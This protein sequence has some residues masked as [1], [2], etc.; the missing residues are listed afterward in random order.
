MKNKLLSFVLLIGIQTAYSQ[1][2]SLDYSSLE[3]KMLKSDAAIKEDKQKA[4]AKTWL[5]R[6]ELFQDINDVNIQ[7]IR[8]GMSTTEAKIFYKAPLEIKN[9]QTEKGAG[10][11][12]DY[13]RIHLVFVNGKLIDWTEIKNLVENPLAESYN[14]FKKCISI[15]TVGKYKKDL[16]TDLERFKKQAESKGVYEYNKKDFDKALEFFEYSYDINKLPYFNGVVDTAIIYNLGIV[17]LKANKNDKAVKYFKEAIVYH[18]GES[19]SY[20]HLR[21]AYLAIGDT[22]SA[23]NILKEGADKYPESTAMLIELINY[24]LTKGEAKTALE[25]LKLAKQKDTTNASFYFAEG[26]LHEKLNEPELALAA[27]T[28]AIQLDPKNFNS[29][30]NL[31]AFYYNKAVKMMAT[32]NDIMD[33]KKYEIAKKDAEFV[34]KQAIPYLE[35]AHEIKSDD[36]STSE[37]LKNLYFRLMAN[38]A[39]LKEKFEKI[40]A[41]IEANKK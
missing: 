28:K 30:Y 6:G 40:K 39:T 25:Y 4:K 33:N 23:L 27:Y 2:T 38:D 22:V 13:E 32:A 9:V 29:F 26:T 5:E 41:E 10:E 1:Q 35:K 14:S 24:Y 7:T 12:Y 37:T 20:V 19:T 18:Y 15:D 16:K 34:F 3:R 36:A 17:A 31:G 21:N 8:E 11:E